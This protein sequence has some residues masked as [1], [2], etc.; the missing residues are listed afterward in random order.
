M[1]KSIV[2]FMLTCMILGF[3]GCSSGAKK[4]MPF[5]IAIMGSGE[6]TQTQF[7]M[8]QYVPFSHCEVDPQDMIEFDFCG[9]HYWGKYSRET[10][11]FPYKNQLF[12]YWFY[13]TDD[14]ENGTSLGWVEWNPISKDYVYYGFLRETEAEK[15]FVLPEEEL[16]K[17]ANS[18]ASEFIDVNKFNCTF[19]QRSE[20]EKFSDYFFDYRRKIED[21][22]L[23]ERL[24]LVLSCEGNVISLKKTT[25]PEWEAAILLNGEDYYKEVGKQLDSDL[26]T[27]AIQSYFDKEGIYD[28]ETVGKAMFLLDEKN[29]AVSYMIKYTYK[30]KDITYNNTIR[31]IVSKE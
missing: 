4:E 2:L 25:V 31:L 15:T 28:W 20:G 17:T 16:E 22:N 18:I 12:V 6:E 14:F 29:A 9:T 23:S 3:S 27:E 13:D 8:D 5:K 1:K 30:I 24:F 19:A 11:Y 7:R 21:I 26:V 10:Y